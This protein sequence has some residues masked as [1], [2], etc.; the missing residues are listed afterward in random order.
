MKTYDFAYLQK[1]TALWGRQRLLDFFDEN[2]MKIR[3]EILQ[4]VVEQIF[5]IEGNGPDKK[6]LACLPKPGFRFGGNLIVLDNG[7]GVVRVDQKHQ[8]E[9]ANKLNVHCLHDLGVANFGWGAKNVL[10]WFDVARKS[11]LQPPPLSVIGSKTIGAKAMP[12]LSIHW[13]FRWSLAILHFQWKKELEINPLA[14]QK[15]FVITPLVHEHIKRAL[16]R[17]YAHPLVN[18]QKRKREQTEN[19]MI[20]TLREYDSNAPASLEAKREEPIPFVYSE[21]FDLR[22]LLPPLPNSSIMEMNFD[23]DHWLEDRR[24]VFDD[25][26]SDN[27]SEDIQIKDDQFPDFF[28]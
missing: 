25:D 20:A 23:T 4:V 15:E 11:G 26:Y 9:A 6:I 24:S 7:I 16:A 8:C 13:L 1:I 5:D 21:P 27:D 28:S 14:R 17:P 10:D 18:G 22:K 12:A 19:L 2:T 3:K